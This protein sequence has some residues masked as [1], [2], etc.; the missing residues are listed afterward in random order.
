MGKLVQVALVFLTFLSGC[1][2]TRRVLAEAESVASPEKAV[3]IV[4]RAISDYCEEKFN[5]C[6]P[7]DDLIKARGRYFYAAARAGDAAALRELYEQ[8]FGE[9]RDA[10]RLELKSRLLKTAEASDDP[11]ILAAAAAAVSNDRI[12]V[13]DRSL[14]MQ[15]LKRAW[16]A[17]DDRSAGRVAHFYAQQADHQN[18]Y[19]WSL[20]CVRT[21]RRQANVPA[22][23]SVFQIELHKLEAALTQAQVSAIQRAASVRTPAEVES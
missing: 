5:R 9:T 12:D 20:R 21:C 13:I 22:G 19:L 3:K 11:D 7:P 18:A 17:G 6:Y 16:Q 1:S 23:A 14:Q 10:V 8:G 15:F 4:D 2:D